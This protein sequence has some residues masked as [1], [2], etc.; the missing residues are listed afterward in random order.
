K[1]VPGACD[2]TLWI[3]ERVGDYSN[4][5]KYHDR[6]PNFDTPPGY[7]AEAWL[8]HEVKE[9]LEWRFPDGVPQNYIERANYEIDV[10]I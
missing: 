6:M 1:E 9:G 7:D 8:R 3:A 10:I 2:T 4:V 5:W